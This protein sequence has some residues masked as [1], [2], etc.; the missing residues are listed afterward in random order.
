[1]KK[2]KVG[3]IGCGKISGAYFKGCK[4]FNIL[5]V[6]ACSDVNMAAAEAAGKEYGCAATSV[7]DL[8]A[9][10]EIDIV[11]NLTIPKVHAEV[12]IAA[13]EAGKHVH[14]EKPLGVT[15]EDGRK[16]LEAAKRTN[17]LISCAPDTFMGGGIQTARKLIDDGWIGEPVGATAF[18]ASHGPETWHP[19]PGFLYSFGGGPML[20]MGPYYITTL[21]NLV[22]PIKRV[23]GSTRIT[24]PERMITSQP[25]YGTMMKVEVPT[26]VA[27]VMDFANG[28]VGSI[29]MSFDIW[30]HNL[31][32]IEIYGTEGS[33]VV[34][35]PNRFDG[36]VLVKRAGAKEWSDIPLTHSDTVSR[37]IGV[38]DLAYAIRGGRKV[39]PS[40]ELA[41]HVLDVMCS[42]DEASKAGHH[43]QIR[44]SVDR[45]NP[46][47]LNL[48]AGTLDE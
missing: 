44:S 9:N 40:G 11:V 29:L 24:F 7:K 28:A 6:V 46:L 8:L 38:A 48:M 5:D 4:A 21:V 35:D 13:F 23:T 26:L 2:V 33:M 34:P 42:F 41:Y 36:Q 20:D 16:V 39:R 30:G 18:M 17:R 45:P 27:G 10:T 3:I 31:P 12:D 32:R 14:C 43:V 25:L 1:M 15:R 37:G 22:G 19:N 47:P